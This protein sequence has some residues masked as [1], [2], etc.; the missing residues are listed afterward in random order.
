MEVDTE[1]SSDALILRKRPYEDLTIFNSDSD[2]ETETR[3]AAKSKPAL[4]GKTTKGR[5]SGLA[6]A[7]AELKA[8]A[9]S[10]FSDVQTK[11]PAKMGA[12]ELRA[13][14]GRSAALILEVAQKSSNLK[15]GF[16]KKL[17]ESAAALQAI[18]DALA[19]RTEAEET[20]KLRADNGRLRKEVD[21]LKAEVKAHRR[22]FTEIRSKVAVINEA[23]TS[24][25]QDARMVDSIKASIISTI[26]VMLNARFAELEERLPPAKIQ[27]PPLSADKRRES[28]QQIAV[29]QAQAV[30]SAPPLNSVP[31]HK[32][33]SPAALPAPVAGCSS[34][35]SETTPPQVVQGMSWSTVVKKGKKGKQPSAGT[36]ATEA[37]TV[38]KAPQAVKPK[39]TAPRT[40]AVVVTLQPEAEQKGVTYAQVLE[41][42]EQGIKLQELGI[43]GGLKVRR[44]ATGARV[45]ELP[46]AQSDQADKL[47]D[48]LRTVLDGVAG[49]VHPIRKVDIKSLAREIVPLKWLDVERLHVDPCYMGMVRVTCSVAAAKKLS[50]AGRLLVGWSS[51][52]VY[53]LEQRPLRCYKCMG[54]GHTRI[55]CPFSADRGSLC[56]RCG[57]SGHK[58]AECTGKLCCAVCAD[59]GKPSRH[60][61][62]SKECNPPSRKVRW[63]SLARPTTTSDSARPRRKLQ[64]QH[65]RRL[66]LSSDE[67]QPLRRGS[68]STAAVHGGVGIDLAVACEPYYVPPLTHWVGDVDD[69]VAVAETDN[70]YV[71]SDLNAKSRAWGNPATNPR[72]RAVQVWALLSD[73]SLLNRGLAEPQRV[74]T[75]LPRWSLGQYDRDMVKEGDSS[76]EL[77]GRMRSSLKKICDAAMPRTRRRLPRR[78]VYWWSPEIAV[79]RATCCRV[80]R[81]YVRCRRRNGLD[82]DLE[83]APVTETLPP[84][85]LLRLVEELFPHPGEHV[86]PQMASRSVIET[87]V[88]PPLITEREMEMALGRLRAKKTAPGPDGVPGPVLCGALNT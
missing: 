23:S 79:L 64:C 16:G 69:T 46:R 53:V 73:L 30:L 45:L 50:D 85:L 36:I 49:V 25:T 88:A 21:S 32:R 35:V 17:R 67:S 43:N 19:S 74:S 62:G 75:T 26:G 78:H 84:E 34:A 40:A 11:D 5:G 28:A 61:M 14:A 4:R 65:E 20:R 60:V 24:S 22:D 6:R 71:L 55:L 3:I 15:G 52:R 27:R 48:K 54:L 10:S 70:R 33:V 38:P 66:Q 37:H 44:S 7:K 86:P 51:A 41:R 31:L 1:L 18:V 56:F 13:Q 29:S 9:K 82:T 8:K 42:A 63:S 77:A 76:E 72:G 58:S 2:T 87:A 80:R 81:A 12:E 59:A 68:G 39:L 57:V 47:A 83:G